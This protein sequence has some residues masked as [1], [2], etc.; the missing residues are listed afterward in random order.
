[1]DELTELLRPSWGSEKWILEGWEQIT[2]KEKQLIQ[3]RVD[4]LFQNGL[5]FEVKQDKL[6]Y[7]YAF[8]LLAQLEVLAIQVPLKFEGK[9]L[10]INHK[11]RM[12][13]QLLD[14]IF[15]GI[16]F[17]KI[18]YMLC[19]P[20]AYPPPYNNNIEVICNFIRSE[21]CP[22]TAVCTA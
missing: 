18:L 8:S 15:H 21:E 22:K 7:I 16:V 9:M 2:P 13:L 3:S 12:R 19:A 11:K 1:M 20:Y 4:E 10:S 17:T 5:P 6:L 14:E